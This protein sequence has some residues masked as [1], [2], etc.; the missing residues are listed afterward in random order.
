[1][2]RPRSFDRDAALACALEAFWR[3]GYDQ[4][5]ISDLTEAMGINPPSLYAAFGDKQTLFD[6]VVERY[7]CDPTSFI[8]T[9]LDEPAARRA[10]EQLLHGAA[11]Q[12]TRTDQP[13]GC[14]VLSEPKL[15]EQR[16][17]SLRSLSERIQRGVD[18]GD[19][20]ATTDAAALSRYLASV[21]TGMSAAARDGAT[22]AELHATADL[23]LAALPR[24]RSRSR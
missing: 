20:P 15:A 6:E 7:Q 14:M 19:L 12:Y 22:A 13:P 23:A 24:S 21:L 1:M 3:H 10:I 18:E 9:A 8:S 5:S 16:A 4:T 11:D 17:E 2:A